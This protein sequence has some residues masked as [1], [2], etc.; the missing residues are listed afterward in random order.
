MRGKG[1]AAADATT[2]NVGKLR[3]IRENR[4]TRE[5]EK[6][7]CGG[8]NCLKI[9][10]TWVAVLRGECGQNKI[11]TVRQTETRKAEVEVDIRSIGTEHL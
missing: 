4:Q 2:I 7:S 9:S 3:G 1:K 8:G 6:K 5:W 10:R 11:K